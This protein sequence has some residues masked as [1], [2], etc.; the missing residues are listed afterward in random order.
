[1]LNQAGMTFYQMSKWDEAL[2]CW[3]AGVALAEADQN[4]YAQAVYWGNM[5][6]V[7]QARGENGIRHSSF[8]RRA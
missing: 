4:L 1:M 7:Y 3:Q 5:G 6:V 2:S 8:I